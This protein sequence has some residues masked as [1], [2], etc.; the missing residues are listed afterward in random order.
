MLVTLGNGTRVWI[1]AT[2]ATPGAPGLPDSVPA[3]QYAQ[4][5]QPAVVTER[6]TEQMALRIRNALATKEAVFRGYLNAGIVAPT[7]VLAIAINVHAVDGLW[8]SWATS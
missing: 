7:D 2:C 5:G 4:P 8:G 1:E 3:P 6:P